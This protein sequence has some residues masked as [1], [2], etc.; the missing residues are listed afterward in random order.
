MLVEHGERQG[1]ERIL[2]KKTAAPYAKSHEK[3]VASIKGRKNPP[4]VKIANMELVAQLKNNFLSYFETSG[5]PFA[6]IGGRIYTIHNAGKQDNQNNQN[7]FLCGNIGFPLEESEEVYVLENRLLKQNQAQIE[8]TIC[9]V[10][11][12]QY[13]DPLKKSEKQ[14]ASLDENFFSTVKDKSIHRLILINVVNAYKKIFFEGEVDIKKP[15]KKE[16]VKYEVEYPSIDG[17]FTNSSAI[18]THIPFRGVLVFGKNV[19]T[20][21]DRQTQECLRDEKV[22]F[23]GKKLFLKSYCS[24][25]ELAARY[26]RALQDKIGAYIALNSQKYADLFQKNQQSIREYEQEIGEIGLKQNQ[27]QLKHGS[28]GFEKR[29]GENY[30]IFLELNPYVMKRSGNYYAFDRVKLGTE[31]RINSKTLEIKSPCTVLQDKRYNHPFVY[32]TNTIC[33]HTNDRWKEHGIKF[34]HKYQINDQTLPR[35]LALLLVEANKSM[36]LG[37]KASKSNKIGVI[38][39]DNFDSLPGGY[40]EARRHGPIHDND[41][42]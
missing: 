36:T 4:K 40:A 18:E 11:D 12:K 38:Q 23:R 27:F 39:I 34:N 8:Q 20:I 1:L 15:K 21:N 9:N 19:Y 14:I 37:Y 3:I 29:D 7:M 28:I 5:E 42:K 16:A 35:K 33:Y 25:A 24:L 32:S 22:V 6:V 26:S 17:L 13:I 10:V 30:L 31:L 2:S 41:L